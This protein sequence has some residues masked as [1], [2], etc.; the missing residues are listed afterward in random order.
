MLRLVLMLTITKL[1]GFST[2]LIQTQGYLPKMLHSDF[3]WLT[4]LL[5]KEVKDLFHIQ[6][7]QLIVL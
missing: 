2:H 3:Y 1:S 4:T 6:S 5:P 7:N